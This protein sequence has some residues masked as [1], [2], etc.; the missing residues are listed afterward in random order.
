MPTVPDVPSASSGPEDLQRRVS[1]ADETRVHGAL[2]EA[3]REYRA[4]LAAYP[5]D[6]SARR[7]LIATLIAQG[8]LSSALPLIDQ[9]LREDASDLETWRDRAAI[10][11]STADHRELLRSLQAIERLDPHDGAALLE[12]Y[13]L[14]DVAGATEEAYRCLELYLRDG[15]PVEGAPSRAQLRLKLGEIAEALGRSE[16]AQTSYDEAIASA[17]ADVVSPAAVRAAQLALKSGRPDLALTALAAAIGTVAPGGEPPVELLALRADVLLQVERPEEAQEI[18]D[19]LRARDPSDSAALAGAARARIEQGKHPEAREILHHGL[20]RVPRTEA[21]VLAL[22]EAESGSGDLLAAERAVREGLEIIPKGRALWTRLAEI[23]SAR[24]DWV[25]AADA[26]QHAIDLD[27]N[28]V[29]SLLGAAFVAEQR[30]RPSDALSFYDRAGALAPGDGRVWTRR[31]LALAAVQRHAEAVESFDRALA[32][33]P[34]SDAAREG[35]KL[36]DRERRVR[37]TEVHGLAAL[38]LESQLGRPV[39]KN[40]LFVQLKVPFDQLDPVLAA[41][42]REVKI[43]V[44]SLEPAAF[45]DLEAR[46]CRLIT[47]ALE[48]RPPGIESRGLTVV[49]VAALSGPTDTL[50]DVQRLF[51]YLDTVLR[52]DIRPENLRLTPQAEEVARRALQLPAGQRT[53]FGLVRTLQIGIFQ[54]RVVKAVERASD[55][56]HTPLPSVNLSPHS[57][58]FGGAD[59]HADGSQFFS[60]QNAPVASP[61]T[62]G[63]RRS[64]AARPSRLWPLGVPPLETQRAAS[65]DRGTPRCLACGGIASMTHGCGATLCTQCTRQFA[66][67]PKCG[68]PFMEVKLVPPSSMSAAGRSTQPTHA[69]AVRPGPP[70]TIL[71]HEASV[72]A[73]RSR[74][75]ERSRSAVST[76]PARATDSNARAPT[77]RRPD[78]KQPEEKETLRSGPGSKAASSARETATKS[79]P[80]SPPAPPP[81]RVRRDK[82]DDEPRL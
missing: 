65:R 56:A 44:P 63:G 78:G 82:P 45:A 34:E 37:E 54:A 10:Y 28:A 46:S 43:D 29:S 12:E 39:T 42:S 19:R 11:R 9:L 41:V 69:L 27:P 16:D 81:V 55:S 50:T 40:D 53:L 61:G 59:E 23:A 1:Q 67:C 30:G 2:D 20:P 75:P 14:S 38:H 18:Y 21:L 25:E 74:T 32:I 68:A 51:A 49:D 22:A 5:N 8:D 7:G 4:I 57:P 60:S 73:S 33:D 17:E 80:P 3:G 76:E 64:S 77:A 6:R 71:P 70:A 62:G 24:D 15:G 31:G 47:T 58:E 26:Y 35:K 13:Q 79:L 66:R 36:A 72:S 52:M 48:R